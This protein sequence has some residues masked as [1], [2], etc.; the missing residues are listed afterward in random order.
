MTIGACNTAQSG[1][2]GERVV[3]TPMR[4]TLREMP[5]VRLSAAAA[6]LIGALALATTS[7]GA[8]GATV[9]ATVT[10]SAGGPT[11]TFTISFPSPIATGVKGKSVTFEEIQASNTNTATF[12]KKSCLSSFQSDPPY[13]NAAGARVTTSVRPSTRW[14][15]GSYHLQVLELKAPL[16][17]VQ[18][19]CPTT[20]LDE[21]GFF[22][23]K[24]KL[25]V[26]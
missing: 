16:C 21:T 13:G 11:A 3:C 2:A 5:K 20:S 6:V 1:S 17:F 12:T 15:A 19:T 7:L 4:I 9:K 22:D 8:Q 18:R 24:A 26:T 14:C 23:L 10:P 25:K